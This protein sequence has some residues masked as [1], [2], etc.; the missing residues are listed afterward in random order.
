M[1]PD[2]LTALAIAATVTRRIELGTSVLQVP[3]RNP[4]DLAQRVL[5]THLMVVKEGRA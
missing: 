1:L 5:T 4:A 3:L 2:P